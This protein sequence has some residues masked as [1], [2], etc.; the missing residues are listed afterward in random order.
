MDPLKTAPAALSPAQSAYALA[1][2]NYAAA[3]LA[4]EEAKAAAGIDYTRCETDEAIDLMAYRE[5]GI[6]EV[7]R[8]GALQDALTAAELGLIAWGIER[9]CSLAALNEIPVLRDLEKRAAGD[10]TAR[11]K[12]V[13]ACLRLAA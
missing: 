4:A 12:V 8:I 1:L 7:H 13:A 6:D 11:A 9:V 10:V 5:G 2:A 3:S